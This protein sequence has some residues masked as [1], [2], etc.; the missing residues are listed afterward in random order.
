MIARNP[1]NHFDE[2]TDIRPSTQT[3][4]ESLARSLDV[5]SSLRHDLHSSHDADADKGDPR[6]PRHSSHGS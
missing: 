2:A 5:P 4:M 6:S 3:A 1:R